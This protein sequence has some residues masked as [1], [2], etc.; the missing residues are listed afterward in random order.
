MSDMDFNEGVEAAADLIRQRARQNG[1]TL[2]ITSI[3]D[4]VLS[5]RR[6]SAPDG[7]LPPRPTRGIM[8]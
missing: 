8:D 2:R 3:V 4:D 5:L 6:T 1:I 7:R